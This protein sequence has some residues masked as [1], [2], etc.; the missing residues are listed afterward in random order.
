MK[1]IVTGGGTGGHIYP[2]LAIADEYKKQFD[3][4]IL[5][6]GTPDSLESRLVP[7]YG[8]EFKTVEVKGFQRKIS[9]ENIKRLYMAFK[10]TAKAKK[11]IKEFNPDIVI[12]TGG[13][14]AGPV[15]LAA[16][17]LGIKTA[18][19]EQNSFP[20]ITNKLLAKKVD[21]V[22]VGFEDAIDRLDSKSKGIYVGNPV[23]SE[24][25]N[26]MDKEDAR[27]KIGISLTKPF[28]LISGGS[29]GSKSINDSFIKIIPELI[30]KD[31]GFIFSTGEAKFK[32]IEKSLKSVDLLDNQKITPY[33]EN[34]GDYISSSDLCIVSAGATTIAEINAAGRAGIII[35]KGYTAENHQEYNAK[36]FK[37]SG[38]GDYIL[39][40]ELTS[41]LLLE[42]IF[43]IINNPDIL[44]K[45]EISSKKMYPDN[46]C[47]TIISEMEKL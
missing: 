33:I 47:K 17:K 9:V 28:I 27:K 18:I 19:H 15:C 26:P 24:F 4:K 5:Y 12:G 34:M 8:Y 41:T 46:P 30:N 14:V 22:F 1:I 35:P 32:E 7:N 23:R 45:M 38:A 40:T 13:Y 31:I 2:A 11:I 29:G 6:I 42:K 37:K 36:N 20:G 16:S 21:K 39:E 10:A 44:E 3:A 25:L 43:Q